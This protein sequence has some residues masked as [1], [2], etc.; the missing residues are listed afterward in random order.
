MPGPAQPQHERDQQDAGCDQHSPA[1]CGAPAIRVGVRESVDQEEQAAGD[2]ERSGHIQLRT[3]ARTRDE[4]ARRRGSDDRD[5]RDGH[6]DVEVPAP[7]EVLGQ[8][9]AEQ[10]ADGAARAGDRAQDAERASAFLRDG[11]RRGEDRERGRRE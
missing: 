11:E 9:A 5:D 7:V 6:V 4:W 1:V 10:Q 3:I 2:E 8:E